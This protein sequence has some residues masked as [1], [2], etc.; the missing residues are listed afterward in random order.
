[1]TKHK[2]AALGCTGNV[3]R[4]HK[5]YIYPFSICLTEITWYL[6][7][8]GHVISPKRIRQNCEQCKLEVR[9]KLQNNR[10]IKAVDANEID[11]DSNGA[12][13]YFAL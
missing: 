4:D 12:E 8:I 6:E 9:L 13:K 5:N 1:M 3:G 7:L 10:L 2:I 11:T